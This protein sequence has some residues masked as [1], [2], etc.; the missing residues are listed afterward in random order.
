[1]LDVL[2]V[3]RIHQGK[4]YRSHF[5]DEE[6]AITDSTNPYIVN[7][8]RMTIYEVNIFRGPRDLEECFTNLTTLGSH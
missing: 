2:H 1:M 3:I 8:Q 7:E 6:L 5:I 4:H